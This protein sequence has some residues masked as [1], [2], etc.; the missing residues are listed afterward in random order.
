VRYTY[1]L[2][3]K[4]FRRRFTEAERQAAS[5]ATPIV[6]LERRLENISIAWALPIPAPRPV[7]WSST[8]LLVNGRRTTCPHPY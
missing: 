6:L 8:A 4:Q 3:E 7:C 5:P 1:G 2:L